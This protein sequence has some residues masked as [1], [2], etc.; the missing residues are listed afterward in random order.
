[1]TVEV[2]LFHEQLARAFGLAAGASGG[3]P[4]NRGWRLSAAARQ[5]VLD[6]VI[7]PYN[8][9]FGQYKDPQNLWGFAVKAQGAVLR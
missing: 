4:V 2:R 5:T 1:M 9:L 6:Q 3:D 8:R 7:Y